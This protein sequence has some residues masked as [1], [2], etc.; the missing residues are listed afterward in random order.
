MQ[1]IYVKIPNYILF[2]NSLHCFCL[3]FS[4]A[5]ESVEASI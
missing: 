5:Y 2:L 1:L 3:F 4:F